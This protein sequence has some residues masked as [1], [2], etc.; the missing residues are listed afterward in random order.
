LGGKV[1]IYLLTPANMHILQSRTYAHLEPA[2]MPMALGYLGAVL[3][4]RGHEVTMRDQAATLM[5]NEAVLDEIARTEPDVLGISVLTGAWHN[6]VRLTEQVRQRMPGVRIVMGNTHATYFCDEILVEG[7]ADFVV[8]G[9][10]EETMAELVDVMD[11]NGDVA[12][13]KGIGWFDG[14]DVRRNPDRPPIEDLDSLPYPA[15]DMLDLDAW[16]YQKIPLVNLKAHPLPVMASRGCSY[17]CSFCS[18]DK[19]VRKFRQRE[20]GKVVDE[21]SY[22]VDRHGFKCFGFNDSYFPWDTDSGN[23]FCDRIRKQPWY[24]DVK[25][26]TETR[27]DRVDDQLMAAM[28]ASGLHAVFFG[29]ESGNQDV[30]RSLGKGT[31]VEQ[32]REAVRVAHRHGV[33]VIGFFMIGIPG[34][35]QEAVEETVR[36]A[37]DTG[38]DIAKFAVTV[39]YPGS[40]LFERLGERK[41]SLEDCD[42]FTSWFD[43]T[44]RSEVPVWA[45]Q[46]MSGE[47]LVL[48]QRSAMVRFYARP[49]YV[50]KAMRDNLFSFSEMAFGGWVLLSRLV[51]G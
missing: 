3:R 34:E 12:S 15:W 38:V 37:I 31:T 36:F 46:G 50:W 42:Q 2:L 20:I 33:K 7:H 22:M 16:R 27:V 4:Q 41:L 48:L 29:F 39:P 44:G 43:W 18:Q 40:H 11:G 51:R 13:V 26:V 32:G 23:E 8:F 14:S 19:I 6:V 45:P 9:E 47:D 1:R 28:K 35:T 25:W 24:G 21:I 5:S 10:G 17:S 49:T 30:L